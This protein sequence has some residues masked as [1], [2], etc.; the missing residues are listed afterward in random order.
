MYNRKF[1]L[2][3]FAVFI[4]I[5]CVCGSCKR[6]SSV[7]D[8]YNHM[9]HQKVTLPLNRMQCFRN[10][11]PKER[12]GLSM[13]TFID[14]SECTPCA[15]DDIQNWDIF[16]HE[17]KK[18]KIDIDYIFIVAPQGNIAKYVNLNVIDTDCSVY[19][20]T[21]YCFAEENRFI[22]KDPKFHSFVV[23]RNNSIVFVG[24]PT[25]NE[26]VAKLYDKLINN[27]KH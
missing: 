3:L 8:T 20:D 10:A 17:A 12:P 5:V 26:K 9:Y 6:N 15:I 14:S 23:D 2:S 7:G 22:P 18:K 24:N 16:V 25:R 11:V 13:I 27:Y 4:C 21:A 19:I 1:A